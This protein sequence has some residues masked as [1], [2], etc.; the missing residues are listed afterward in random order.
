[1]NGAE[2]V[3]SRFERSL[4]VK[5]SFDFEL[6][7]KL[8]QLHQKPEWR[9]KQV[10][11]MWN[12]KWRLCFFLPQRRL[13]SFCYFLCETHSGF[14]VFT[15]TLSVKQRKPH[16]FLRRS[17]QLHGELD[18]CFQ[19]QGSLRVGG[20]AGLPLHNQGAA[21]QTQTQTQTQS[22]SNW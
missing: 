3:S 16:Q 19:H 2:Q 20:H 13:V 15:F 17:P 7:V 8:L 14:C 11:F 1:M 9:Q 22:F 18:A 6:V 4:L 12:R 10:Q 5:H 21:P